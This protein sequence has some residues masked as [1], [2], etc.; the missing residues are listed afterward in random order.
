MESRLAMIIKKSP[1]GVGDGRRLGGDYR[2]T[3]VSGGDSSA[4]DGS[5]RS[6]PMGIR[7]S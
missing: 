6:A 4:G 1:T 5:R 7:R 2:A 3:V